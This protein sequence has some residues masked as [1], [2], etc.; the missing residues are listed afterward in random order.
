MK[1]IEQS[2][3]L[4][5]SKNADKCITAKENVTV[6]RR[7]MQISLDDLFRKMDKNL[8]GCIYSSKSLESLL[9]SYELF[10]F[11]QRGRKT[12]EALKTVMTCYFA[13][14]CPIIIEHYTNCLLLAP[15]I[16]WGFEK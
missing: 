3:F 7:A 9:A 10:Y 8:N 11:G 6:P 4:S 16:R 1:I 14:G 13:E 2:Q 5:I 15:K 12:R